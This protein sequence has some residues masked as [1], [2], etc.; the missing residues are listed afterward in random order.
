MLCS[1]CSALHGVNPI[2]KKSFLTQLTQNPLVS[3]WINEQDKCLLSACSENQM[4]IRKVYHTFLD[5]L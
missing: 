1:G 4:D 2:L 5:V 3:G